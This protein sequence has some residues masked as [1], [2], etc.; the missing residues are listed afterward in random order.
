MGGFNCGS[1]PTLL[2]FL[3]VLSG[4]NFGLPPFL[5]FWVEVS[6]FALQGSLW[7]ISLLPLALTSL[8]TFVYCIVFYAFSCGGCLSPRLG[9][10]SS[11]YIYIS[12]FFL[13]LLVPISP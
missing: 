10:T 1:A 9:T 12:P 11:F 5:G 13:L 6:L 3:G 4:I 7:F 8:L 2:L